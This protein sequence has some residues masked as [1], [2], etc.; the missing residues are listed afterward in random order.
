MQDRVRLSIYRHACLFTGL[1]GIFIPRKA[2]FSL[3]YF[4]RIL[5]LLLMTPFIPTGNDRGDGDARL[6]ESDRVWV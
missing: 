6:P 3:Q 1:M 5:F 4:L 2:P